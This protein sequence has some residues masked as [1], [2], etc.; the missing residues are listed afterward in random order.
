MCRGSGER[1]GHTEHG[2]RRERHNDIGRRV[3][4]REEDDGGNELE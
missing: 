2:R 3:R 1:W 4:V